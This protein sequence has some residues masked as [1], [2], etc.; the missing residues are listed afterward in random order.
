MN[1][2]KRIRTG[3]VAIGCLGLLGSLAL[4]LSSFVLANQYSASL[5]FSQFPKP[6]INP[7]ELMGY[8]Y[9]LVAVLFLF[10]IICIWQKAVVGRQ[11]FSTFFLGAIVILMILVPVDPFP[12]SGSDHLLPALVERGL[13]VVLP[14]VIV[15]GVV[16]SVM[17]CK[18]GRGKTER[19]L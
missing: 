5:E 3:L 1:R 6:G 18:R 19:R 11:L 14:F 12:R 17:I 4:A 2:K 10:Q 15:M 7:F 16:S 13:L 9:S 8:R